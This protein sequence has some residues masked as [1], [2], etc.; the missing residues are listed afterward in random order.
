MRNLLQSSSGSTVNYGKNSMEKIAV[1]P[2]SFNPVHPGHM[3]VI[4]QAAAVFDKVIV[5]VAFNPD[6]K[7]DVSVDDRVAMVRE[8]SFCFR[9]YSYSSG[10]PCAEIAVDSTG[11]TLA[12]YCREHG[13]GFVVRGLRNGEDLEYEESQHYFVDCMQE[14]TYT[15]FVTPPEYRLLSSS[16]LRQF[17]RIATEEQF[18]HAYWPRKVLSGKL[19]GMAYR[20]YGGANG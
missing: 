4:E 1:Y 6:K 20:L 10:E 3:H 14:L 13:A 18:R 8:C 15:Y 12:D 16:A 9:E 19:S 17:A 11:G 2:G 7:Y 5:L